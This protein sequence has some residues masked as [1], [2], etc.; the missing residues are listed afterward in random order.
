MLRDR[1]ELL[2]AR[3]WKVLLCGALVFA[4]VSCAVSRIATDPETGEEIVIVEGSHILPGVAEGIEDITGVP[5]E[6]VVGAVGEAVDPD[7]VLD[8]ADD[9]A[10]GNWLEVGLGILGIGAAVAIGVKRRRDKKRVQ[11]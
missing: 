1:V 3:G 8:L 9:A 6:D 2:L 11:A 10:S 4:L 5:V 7:E